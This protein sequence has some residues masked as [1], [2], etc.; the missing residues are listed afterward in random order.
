M[1]MAEAPIRL[2]ALNSGANR[3]VFNGLAL[4]ST[5]RSEWPI[6]CE[7]AC[8]AG[9]R[10]RI[11]MHENRYEGTEATHAGGEQRGDAHASH[12][13]SRET[14]CPQRLRRRLS[15]GDQRNGRV[16]PGRFLFEL[17]QQRAGIPR[18]YRPAP[19]KSTRRHPPTSIRTPERSAA[20]TYAASVGQCLSAT[21]GVPADRPQI[22]PSC[23]YCWPLHTAWEVSL[24]IP[25]SECEHMYTEAAK[26]VFDRMTA[27]EISHLG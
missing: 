16:F 11:G 22:A 20:V 26:L 6:E 21:D 1:L 10:I 3:H 2:A 14:I 12:R 27:S 25:E 15:G 9:T 18:S 7:F 13:S 5:L 8:V 19:A 17:R 23:L 24:S 4:S